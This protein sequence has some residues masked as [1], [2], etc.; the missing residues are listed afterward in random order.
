MGKFV[1]FTQDIWL[2]T[3]IWSFTSTSPAGPWGN[4]TLVYD[5]PKLADD[6]FTYNAYP[7]PQFDEND[8]LLFSYN[9]NG[10][11][12]DIFSNVELYRP[13]FVRVPYA[14]LDPA[15]DTGTGIKIN[16]PGTENIEISVNYPNPFISFTT[17][18]YSVKEREFVELV[19]YDISGRKIA[20]YINRKLD[21]GTYSVTINTSD[22]E[23][24]IYFYRMAGSS[25]ET[26]QMIKISSY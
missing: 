19:I 18:D 20:S 6:A 17:I 22:L 7:H 11:F 9:N 25:S 16:L 26:R 4:K 14:Q 12:W 13:V 1:L 23:E 3:Q 5:T 2:S 8:R 10:N 15:F 24:G 21:P